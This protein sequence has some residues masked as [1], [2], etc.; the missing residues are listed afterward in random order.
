LAN[1]SK[2]DRYQFLQTDICDRPALGALFTD[3]QPDVIMHLS[4][5]SHVDRSI[6]G[7][8]DF[9]ETNIVC[10][11]QLLEAARA[12]WGQLP[13]GKRAGFRFHNISTYEMYGDLEGTDGLFTETTPYAPSSPN[14]ASRT[15]SDH[16]VALSIERLDYPW[17]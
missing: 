9:I 17:F 12:Y 11:Y 14:S 1:L 13:N 3:F 2:S 16:L 15:N 10:T 5:E 6:E 8:A 7:A 4:A